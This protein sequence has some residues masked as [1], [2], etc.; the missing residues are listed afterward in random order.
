MMAEQHEIFDNERVYIDGDPELDVFGPKPKRAQWRHRKV[1]PPW[2]KIGRKVAYL[3]TD[4][5]AYLAAQRTD[6]SAP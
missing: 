2:V 1:G 3:G 4:L 6:P 5:N